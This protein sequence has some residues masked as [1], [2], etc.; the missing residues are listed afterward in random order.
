MSA[1]PKPE[2]A[3][4]S[5]GW[6]LVRAARLPL[7]WWMVAP[8]SLGCFASFW[9]TGDA[10]PV[11]VKRLH[12]GDRELPWPGLSA[13]LQQGPVQCQI[14]GMLKTRLELSYSGRA[15]G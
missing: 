11:L 8:G 7:G 3:S 5:S 12:V 10:Q 9:G 1:H 4:R 6:E 15:A 2:A 13:G 14:L